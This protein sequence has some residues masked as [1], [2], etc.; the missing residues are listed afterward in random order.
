MKVIAVANQKGGV[1]KTTTAVNIAA[2]MSYFG[3]QVLLIDID[4][5]GNA[6]SGVGMDKVNL[7]ASVY[8]VLLES[9]EIKDAVKPTAHDWLDVLPANIDLTGAE[10]ELVNVIARET[11]LRKKIE[12]V[13]KLY[14]YVI[15][16]CPPSL[17]L[18]TLN[19]LTAADS[20]LIPIQC[21]FYALEGLAQLLQT[22]ELIKGHLNPKLEVEGVALTM[23]DGRSNLYNQVRE[24]VK[25]YF[26]AKVYTTIIPRNVRLAE[27][28][29]YGKTILEYDPSSRGGKAYE[30]LTREVLGVPMEEEQ[31]SLGL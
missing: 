18:L 7:K 4:P 13:T 10:I 26:E 17:G 2:Y 25:K 3:R 23:Y 8:D 24:E 12:A 22:I 16:D 20:I 1:G 9:T 6:S 30:N 14:D 21:E 31:L 5:Q 15:I 27:A 19:A 11:R 28:P 29:S